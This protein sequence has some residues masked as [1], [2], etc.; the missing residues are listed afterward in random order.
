MLH[1]PV[2]IAYPLDGGE[3]CPFPMHFYRVFN[4][5]LVVVGGFWPLAAASVVVLQHCCYNMRT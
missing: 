1:L 5:F 3:G 2:Q 4:G